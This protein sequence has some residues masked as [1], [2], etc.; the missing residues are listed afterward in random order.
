MANSNK[1]WEIKTLGEV[2]NLMTGGTPRRNHP[3]YF[4][5]GNIK[6]L[7]SGDIHKKEIHDCGGRITEE[8]YK[9]SNAKYL[10]VGSVLIALNG[11]GKTRGTVALLRTE[12]TCNQSL[13]SINPK[14]QKVLSSEYLF[15]VLDGRYEE[16]RKMTGDSGNDRRG[17]NMPLIRSIEITVPSLLEQKRIVKILD[18]KFGQIDELKGIT[19]RQIVDAKELFGSSAENLFAGENCDWKQVYL[20]DV[21]KINDGT[22]FSPKN[23]SEGDYMYVT[24]KNIKPYRI[25]LSKITYISKKAHDEIY[26][27][28]SPKKGDILYIKDGATAGIA[29]INTID[30]PFSLLSSVALFKC[31]EDIFNNFLL[32]YMNSITGKKNFLEYVGGAAITRLTLVKLKNISIPL[33]TKIEQQKIAKELDEL[34]EETKK[35]EV[36]FRRKITDLEE[37]KKSYLEQAF[38]GNL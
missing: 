17:L 7:V 6:W 16:I 36:I 4:N 35:L 18:E 32:H 13:V 15:R 38:S 31:S 22:H 8:G 33:P 1:D 26:A 21:C 9:N 30:E 20:G 25:D 37:L 5:G 14:D 27:R 34:S 23:S 28:C 29:A 24:A 3:E 11:Q 2:C 12:A 10:P 19:E